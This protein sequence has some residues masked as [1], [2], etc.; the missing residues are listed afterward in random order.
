MWNDSENCVTPSSW[1]FK[2]PDD[3]CPWRSRRWQSH[4]SAECPGGHTEE[5]VRLGDYL[6]SSSEESFFT[7][8]TA[9]SGSVNLWPPMTSAN[10]N[11]SLTTLRTENSVFLAPESP[12]YLLCVIFSLLHF[13]PWTAQR[14]GAWPKWP[15]GKYACVYAGSTARY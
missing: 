4:S 11:S 13:F 10:G 2:I 14:G 12:F 6:T 8:I 7:V 1:S 15:N 9:H 5:Q 3:D